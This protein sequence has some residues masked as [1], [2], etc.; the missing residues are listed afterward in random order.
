MTSRLTS[1]NTAP[2]DQWLLGPCL[3]AV[4]RSFYLSL[5]ILPARIRRTISLAYLLARTADTLADAEAAAPDLRKTCLVGFRRAVALAADGQPH[6]F[7]PPNLPGLPESEMRLLQHS[8]S[9]LDCLIRFPEKPSRHIQK[10]VAT[11]TDGML[12][13][14]DHF[15]QRPGQPPHALKGAGD[16]DQYTYLVAGVVGEFW[17]QVAVSA[18]CLPEQKQ[19]DLTAWGIRF[20]KGLQMI[21]ILRDMGGDL[22]RGRVYLP[23]AS[24]AQCNVTA[25]DLAGPDA[26][27][28]IKPIFGS[29][30]ALARAHLAHG[31]RFIIAHPRHCLKLR[32]AAIWP[33]WIGLATLQSLET[34]RDPLHGPPVRIPQSTTNR[35]I[36]KSLLSVW[37]NTLLTRTYRR[38]ASSAI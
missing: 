1:G 13:D 34:S 11:L 16:L 9:A 21:N 5:A 2:S 19:D 14:F 6:H 30:L 7:N 31:H 29:H 12:F 24:L 22:K 37:S 23:D 10:V 20:G 17:T 36:V 33:L 18:G 15:P 28:Q 25:S 4:S 38:L 26:F 27:Q 32:L 8:P 3:K 35:L